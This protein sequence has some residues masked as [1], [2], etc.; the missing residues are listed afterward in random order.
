[1]SISYLRAAVARGVNRLEP[2]HLP[3]TA[4][5][6]ELEVGVESPKRGRVDATNRIL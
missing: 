1:M 6:G 2:R 5:N 4:V 3:V